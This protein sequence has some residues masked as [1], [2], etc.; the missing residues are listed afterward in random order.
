MISQHHQ[1]SLLENQVTNAPE[2][3]D[4]ECGCRDRDP[5]IDVP[6]LLS[7]TVVVAPPLRKDGEDVK[8]VE[9]WLRRD[10]EKVFLCEMD[11]AEFEKALQGEV[12][13]RRSDG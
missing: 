4:V 9:I 13:T 1:V 10:G 3:Q 5:K 12:W 7:E 2:L 11:L 8:Q 6:S